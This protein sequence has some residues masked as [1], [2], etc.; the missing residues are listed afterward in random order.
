MCTLKVR[1]RARASQLLLANGGCAVAFS[2][3]IDRRT[4]SERRRRPAEMPGEGVRRSDTRVAVSVDAA[5]A[6]V[7]VRARLQESVQG[8]L[9]DG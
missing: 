8:R 5:R 9:G 7:R 2:C 3:E 6:C 1:V 4:H